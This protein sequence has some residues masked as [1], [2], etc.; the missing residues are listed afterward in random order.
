MFALLCSMK[1]ESGLCRASCGRSESGQA[2]CV[3]EECEVWCGGVEEEE[4]EGGGM[5]TVFVLEVLYKHVCRWVCACNYGL[6]SP[7][8]LSVLCSSHVILVI[9]TFLPSCSY[10]PRT[11]ID[12]CALTSLTLPPSPSSAAGPPQGLAEGLRHEAAQQVR[13]DQAVGLGLLLGGEA[14]HGLFQQSLG[15]AGAQHVTGFIL[16]ET[17]DV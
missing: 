5:L 16:F 17:H 1:L 3:G 6:P 7:P 2:Q 4:E 12:V 11:L 15:R 9:V 14:H 8:A 10:F 13:D